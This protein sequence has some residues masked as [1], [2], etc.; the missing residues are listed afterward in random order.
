MKE[1]K[2]LAPDESSIIVRTFDVDLIP[3]GVNLARDRQTDGS[4]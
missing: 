4:F 1:T 3:S 2:M